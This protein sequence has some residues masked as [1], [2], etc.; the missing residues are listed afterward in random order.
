MLQSKDQRKFQ[1]NFNMQVL[2]LILN[3]LN[4]ALVFLFIF[5][6]LKVNYYN[7][8]VSI[9]VKVYSPIAKIFS[10]LPIQALNIFILAILF[11]LSS[12]FIYFSEAYVITTLL[13]V[14][15]IQTVMII[16]RIIFFAVIGGVI[17]SWISP[18]NSNAFL[19]LV[20]E[21]SYKSLMPIRNYIPSAGGL[22][23]SPLF[24][25]IVIN[26]IE[27]FLSDMLRSIV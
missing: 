7:Q 9:F 14:A 15:V 18:S 17:L 23:F 3:I 20:E 19:E 11:K 2:G 16:F 26:L 12:L 1:M 24:V 27:S 10:P 5:S 21:I 8:I 4:Y 6:I 22:D 25:L 13:G